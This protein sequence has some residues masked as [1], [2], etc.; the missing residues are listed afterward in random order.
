LV[1]AAV[2]F[3][4]TLA[5][6][7]D[8]AVAQEHDLVLPAG[9]ACEFELGVDLA[10]GDRRVDR[11]F[12]DADGNPVRTL[13]AGVGSQLTFTNV[14]NDAT[15][16]LRAN[17]AVMRTVFNADGSQTVTSTGHN[18][19]ILFPADVP[20]GP[21]TTLYVG[22]VVYTVDENA[23]FTLQSTTGTATDICAALA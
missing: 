9:E 12:R 23:V 5:L 7:A 19:L 17:G 10:G 20:A 18:V 4:A 3:T 21:S 2:A 15:L 22:R 11:T 8:A 6:A 13:S 14:S 1:A 16:A